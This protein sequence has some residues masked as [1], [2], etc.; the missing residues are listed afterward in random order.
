MNAASV[1]HLYLSLNLHH[2]TWLESATRNEGMPGN[3][4]IYL[5]QYK[6]VIRFPLSMHRNKA[7]TIHLQTGVRNPKNTTQQKQNLRIR[8]LG[9][10]HVGMF[11]TSLSV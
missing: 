6:Y 10:L 3:I 1:R 7:R 2:H 11:S 9:R 4:M 8:H 5:Y